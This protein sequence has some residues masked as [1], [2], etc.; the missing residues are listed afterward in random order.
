MTA[1]GNTPVTGTFTSSST[2]YG[3]GTASGTLKIDAATPTLSLACTEVTYDGK[4]HSCVGTATGIGGAAVTGTWSYTPTSVTAA[5][6]TPV[7]GIF[8]S[9]NANYGGGAVIDTLK[10]DPAA[11]TIT[12]ATPAAVFYGTALSSA[13]L[14]ATAS[15]Q[16]TFVYSPAAGS[17]PPVGN[18]TLSV[19]FTP[20]DTTDFKTATASV[21]LVVNPA[22]PAPMINSISPAFTSAGGTT[23]TLTVNGSGF[24]ANSTV[25]WGSSVLTTQYVSAAQLSA[26]VTATEIAT[27]GTNAITVQTPS[28]GGGTSSILQ[29]EVDS[30]GSGTSAPT[31]SSTTATVTAGS[32]ASYPVTFP[33]TVTNVSLSCLNLPAGATCSYSSSTKTVTIATS[34]TTPAG[35][36]QVTL[37][38]VE[39][40]SGPATAG[41]LLPIL[42][43]PLVFLRKKLAARG[44]WT[45]ACLGLILLAAATLSVGC[46]GSGSGPTTKPQ[47]HQVTSSGAVSL[48][49]Q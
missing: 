41:I 36:Y 33:S 48:T 15:V 13:Q 1:A 24:T 29:F 23:F 4:A 40:V 12:W 45:S 2:N 47:T 17:T 39:T 18:N 20:S 42:L 21:V 5:G 37:V 30:I 27:A 3:G 10:I 22:N 44:I 49:I 7:T 19:T 11:P 14:N 8:I 16:G 31:V 38:F 9:S 34:S 26:Q 43:L 25:Y 28:P 46:G 32:T 35:T 6:S